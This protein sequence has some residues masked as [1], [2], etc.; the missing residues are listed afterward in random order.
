MSEPIR[1]GI[2]G[3][4]LMGRLHADAF[5]RAGAAVVGVVDA[6]AEVAGR[7]A[8]RCGAVPYATCEE[9]LEEA[10]PGCVSICT[11]P[12]AHAAPALAAAAHG[13]PVLCEKPLAENLESAIRLTARLKAARVPV[14][15]GFFHHFF[16]PVERALELIRAGDL[17]G[18]LVVRNRFSIPPNPGHGA[19]R[20][21]RE[22]SGGGAVM[23]TAIHS[24]ALFT[25]LSGCH[26]GRVSGLVRRRNP[27][28]GL[29]DTVL[30]LLETPQGDLGIVES[31]EGAPFRLYELDVQG[32]R[33][34]ARVRWDP[35]S[36]RVRTAEETGCRE[37][38]VAATDALDRIDA[39]IAYFLACASRG[40]PPQRATL[41]EAVAAMRMA[42]AM[43]RAA[44]SGRPV[45][46]DWKDL[47]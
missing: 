6:D 34:E 14:M 16:E 46:L 19:W 31:Y 1:V 27:A 45:E 28:G 9:L 43:Y 10:A 29:E 42:D 44:G 3:C 13:L 21:N 41:D 11:P 22:V 37:V 20:Q 23:N 39:G 12:A 5:G 30:A 17:G 40:S 4:G 35:P 7:L 15:V 8:A 38:P 2:V 25:L 36:L 24:F 32:P 33:G 18:P 26:P 47:A